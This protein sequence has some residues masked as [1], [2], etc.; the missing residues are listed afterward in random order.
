MKEM[1]QDAGRP[2]SRHY[3]T[4]TIDWPLL[5]WLLRCP[6]LRVQDLA[7]FAGLSRST[8]SRRM[9]EMEQL[10]LIEWIVPACIARRGAERLYHLSN[11]GIYLLAAALGVDA[12]VLAKTWATDERR[13]LNLLPR[14]PQLVRVQSMV[15]SILV[16]APRA[17]SERGMEVG[18]A[19]HWVRGYTHRFTYRDRPRQLRVDA[20][21]ALHV[22]RPVAGTAT[23][24]STDVTGDLARWE[25]RDRWHA[26]FII[27][28]TRLQDWE[29]AKRVVEA[30]LSYRESP[31]R[32]SQYGGFPAVLILAEDERHLERW[33]WLVQEVAHVRRVPPLAG[34]VAVVPGPSHMSEPDPPPPRRMGVAV[35]R[36]RVRRLGAPRDDPLRTP[37]R[38]PPASHGWVRCT[39]A[40]R[41]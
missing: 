29:A 2:R 5:H 6:F 8:A 24:V 30:L 7:A 18:G 27:A 40:S 15:G 13:L 19:W 21:L 35:A 41:P 3:R 12:A 25:P 14:V 38:C 10:G 20:A 39:V 4:D 28:D 22:T 37:S 11:L 9:A 31:E 34:V 26:A 17:L 33:R 32:W 36:A 23:G 16:G 1:R